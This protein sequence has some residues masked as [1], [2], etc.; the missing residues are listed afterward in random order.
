MSMAYCMTCEDELPNAAL[1]AAECVRVEGTV[2][3]E[4]EK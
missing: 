2:M 1:T 4:V 3:Q